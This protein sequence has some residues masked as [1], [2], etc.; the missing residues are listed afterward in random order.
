MKIPRYFKQ[1]TGLLIAGAALA[2][3]LW[4]CASAGSD[5]KT[6]QK[7]PAQL[8]AENCTRCHNGR[9]PGEF[10]DSQW[11]VIAHHMRVRANLTAEE[12]RQILAFLKA[13]N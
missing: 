3:G 2:L 11:D 5:T 10:S 6:A 4:G 8:W 1:W 9:P 12:H 7:G 13:S